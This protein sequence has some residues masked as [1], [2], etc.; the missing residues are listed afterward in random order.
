M[1]DHEKVI[2]AL[3]DELAEA[4][5]AREAIG[6]QPRDRTWEAGVAYGKV[7]SFSFAIA[8]LEREFA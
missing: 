8:I 1:H 2:R 6:D 7:E 3:R 4:E 5:R